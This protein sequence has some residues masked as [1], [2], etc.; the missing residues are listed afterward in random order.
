M[1]F[2]PPLQNLKYQG[3]IH[4]LLHVGVIEAPETALNYV[5]VLANLSFLL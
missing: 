2:R 5:I 4:I 3:Q 1:I